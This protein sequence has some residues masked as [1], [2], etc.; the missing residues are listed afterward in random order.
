[1]SAPTT[2][3]T[4]IAAPTPAEKR[5]ITEP[6]HSQATPKYDV[7]ALVYCRDKQFPGPWVVQ[8][9]IPWTE[10]GVGEWRYRCD[11]PEGFKAKLWQSASGRVQSEV[12]W[13]MI[14]GEDELYTLTVT[15]TG[16][17]MKAGRTSPGGIFLP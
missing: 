5:I 8:L 2:F 17:G 10:F 14:A 3:A 4:P 16:P 9:Q 6:R 7:G 15:R 1:M 13:R 12:S 11:R